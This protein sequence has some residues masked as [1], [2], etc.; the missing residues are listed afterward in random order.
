MTT[1]L[2]LAEPRIRDFFDDSRVR[3]FKRR[4]LESILRANRA[5]WLLG[6]HVSV[7]QFV[8]FLLET[9]RLRACRLVGDLRAVNRRGERYEDIIRFTW[10]ELSP[11]E[12]GLAL[13]AQAYLSH[14][15]ALFLRGYTDQVPN[16]VFINKE[17]GAKRTAT[18]SALSQAAI[19]RAFSHKQ[20]ESRYVFHFESWRFVRINGKHSGRLEVGELIGPKDEHLEVTKTERTLIDAAVRP[21]YAGGVHQVLDAYKAAKDQF[22]INVLLATLKK[23]DYAYPY[24]QAIGFYLQRAGYPESVLERFRRLGLDFDFY[25]THHIAEAE[26]QYD[27]TWRLFHPQGL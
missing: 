16:T 24:H 15:T 14:G 8:P 9:G 5:Y 3:V 2:E 19:D 13:W 18:T 1:Q 23:L 26:R 20:R 21:V 27:A 11:Y 25:L 10:G 7:R 17:Q 4:E 6:E 22:S 12:L